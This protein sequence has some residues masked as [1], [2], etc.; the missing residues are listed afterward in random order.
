M[1][2]VVDVTCDEGEA[3]QKGDGCNAQVLAADTDALLPQLSEDSVRSVVKEK[4][5]PLAEI[6]DGLD[7]SSVTLR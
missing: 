4:N 3:V 5:V 6:V 2:K 7:E 1:G